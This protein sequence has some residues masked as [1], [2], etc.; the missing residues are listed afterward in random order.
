MSKE[1]VVPGAEDGVETGGDFAQVPGLG[2]A[3]IRVGVKIDR[4]DISE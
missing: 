4:A 1:K 2:H 3:F